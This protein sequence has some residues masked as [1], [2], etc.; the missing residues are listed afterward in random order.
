M[1]VFGVV[2]G[3][4]AKSGIV[5][6]LVGELTRRGLRVSTIK[7][8]P[9]DLD[10]D[11]PGTGSW[12]QREAGAEEIILASGT[13]HV[14]MRELRRM[15]DEPDVDALLSRL[16]PV[17]LVLLEGFRLSPYPK[18]EAARAGQGR[19][20]LALDDPS[21]LAVTADLPMPAPVPFLPLGDVPRMAN[22][23]LSRAA[24]PVAQ[25]LG[26]PMLAC[27]AMA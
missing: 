26:L 9:D 23:V 10:L 8:V 21:V 22:F 12:A 27:G 18:L 15:E 13:R 2:G 6:N 7:H 16:S 19:R 3:C 11:R 25:G 1:R 14:L 24:A 17:D 4:A 5:R 20:L